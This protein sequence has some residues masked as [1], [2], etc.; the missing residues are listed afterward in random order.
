MASQIDEVYENKYINHKTLELIY[1][2]IL[3]HMIRLNGGKEI[4][5]TDAIHQMAI[6][7]MQKNGLEYLSA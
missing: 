1:Q 4:T 2:K 7:Y 5:F 6:F 3:P